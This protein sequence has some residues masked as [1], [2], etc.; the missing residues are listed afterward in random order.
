V[1]VGSS[2]TLKSIL[3]AVFGLVLG[4]ELFWHLV[5]GLFY[6]LMHRLILV[7]FGPHPVVEND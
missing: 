2:D 6:K 3:F 4:Y 7:K 5:L 1:A